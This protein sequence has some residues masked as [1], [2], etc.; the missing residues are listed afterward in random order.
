MGPGTVRGPG[1]KRDDLADLRYWCGAVFEYVQGPQ[2]P[3]QRVA[4][5]AKQFGGI[6]P[7]SLRPPQCR[8]YQGSFKL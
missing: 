1:T 4:A 6:G 8:A 2:L 5:P 3:C 7:A